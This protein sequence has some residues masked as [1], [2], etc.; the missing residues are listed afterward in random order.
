MRG[1]TIKLGTM[2][3]V[4]L[5]GLQAAMPIAAIM[6]RGETRENLAAEASEK[7]GSRP[8]LL[9]NFLENGRAAMGTA[10]LT[11]IGGTTAPT[12]LTVTKDG[13]TYTINVSTAT[14]LRRRFWGKSSLSEM[15]VGNLLTIIGRWT[16][17]THT[18]INAAFIRDLSI[19]KRFGVFIGTVTDLNG[20]GWVMSTL[21]RGNQTV[22]V[23]GTTKFV[24]RKGQAIS[25]ADVKVNDRV[26]V[27]GLWDS[28]VSTITEVTL[29]KDYSLPA[30]P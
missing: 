20:G 22:T 13:K 2:A 26:R 11:A 8:G 29:V 3:V 19:Q 10:T 21:S 24:N 9:R 16:D 5:L 15:T 23:S 27:R 6:V 4:G 7:A 12:T 28:K 18:A 1:L 14:Q 17:N 30:K 25:Q